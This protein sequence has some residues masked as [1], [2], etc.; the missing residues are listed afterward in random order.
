MEKK[1][2]I[3]FRITSTAICGSDLHLIHGMVPNMPNEFIIGHE[4]TSS[5]IRLH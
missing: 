2:D 3:I 5:L 1:D 4:T